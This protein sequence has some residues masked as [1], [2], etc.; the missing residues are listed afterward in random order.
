[1]NAARMLA[2]AGTCVL[3]GCAQTAY[4]PQAVTVERARIG[5]APAGADAALYFDIRSAVDDRLVAAEMLDVSRTSLHEIVE[6]GGGG[7]MSP[8]DSVELPADTLVR[9]EP[10]GD[11][12][13]LEDLDRDLAAGD[14]V[15][16][17]LSFE[18]RADIE[19]EATV[20]DLVELAEED[21]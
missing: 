9:F 18:H 17:T 3:A 12:V 13:M 7:I 20:V 5:A 2:V 1:M 10:F 14:Q 11:H 8:V 16:V 21:R 6:V 15:T 4:A 19:V